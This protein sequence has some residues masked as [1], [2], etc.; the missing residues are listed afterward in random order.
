MKI[1]SPKVVIDPYD[2][3]PGYGESKISFRSAGGDLIIEIEYD[4][5]GEEGDVGYAKREMKFKAARA[6]IKSLF[7]GPSIFEYEGNS[8]NYTLGVLNEF[9]VS[10]FFRVFAGELPANKIKL[11]HFSIE[12][13]AENIAFNILAEDIILTG[14]FLIT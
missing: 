7:P 11:R 14:E 9:E 8:E 1:G 2:W 4:K 6:F 10:D 12:F 3:L 5:S 13:M